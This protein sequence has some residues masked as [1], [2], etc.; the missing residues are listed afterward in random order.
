MV[1]TA[2]PEPGE[3][4]SLIG[5]IYD[6]I[7]ER[8]HWTGVLERICLLIGGTA[9]SLNV[10]SLPAQ[11][12]ELLVEFG[13]NPLFSESY[14][15]TYGRI[16][17]LF[18]AA[19]L[20][21]SQGDVSTLYNTVDVV[22][23]RSSRFYLEWVGPQG[24]GDWVAGVVIRSVSSLSLLA[25]ARA[26]E[27]G[28]F[29]ESQVALL[30][31]LL[32]HVQRAVV[33]GRLLDG[34][35]A[36]RAGMAALL[37]RI[38]V[39]AF[40]IDCAGVLIHSNAAATT[41]LADGAILRMRNG[42]LQPQD[43]VVARLLGG[44]LSGE[45]AEPVV[46]PIDTLEGKRLVSI[47]PPSQASGLHAILLVTVPEPELPLAGRII[48][49]AYRLT[50]AEL[51]VLVPLLGGKTLDQIALELSIS[52]RTVKAHVQ[53]LFSKTGTTRQ[54]DLVREVLRLAPPLVLG[55]SLSG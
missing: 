32:P 5:T 40:M 1:E 46:A 18:A 49:E 6:C 53:K 10:H 38:S 28:P 13:T 20:H 2:F 48:M 12:P 41:V 35:D 15:T 16:N 7:L 36:Q 52:H 19:I 3:F 55:N 26:A 30:R 34:G 29:A 25:V 31:L 8:G 54:A 11:Q 51:R 27:N 24:W 14:R 21:M 4:S 42:V 43:A 47:V 50:P 23:F 22:E 33:L 17:P 9:A 45:T 39:A 37:D 44:V